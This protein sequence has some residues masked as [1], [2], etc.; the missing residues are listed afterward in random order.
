MTRNRIWTRRSFL[1][2]AS[3]ATAAIAMPAASYARIL[4][5][6]DRIRFGVVGTGGMGSAHLRNLMERRERENLSVHRVCDVYTRRLNAAVRT[7]EGNDTTGTMEY[8]DVLD[9][10]DVDTVLIAT[11]DHWHTK[12]AIEAMDAGKD[13]YVEKPLSHT[14]EQALAC[15]DAVRRTGRTL[16]VGPQGTS[17][18]RFWKAHRAIRENRIGRVTW[19]QG[20]YCRNSRGGQFNWHIDPDAG[21]QQER[22]HD[23][24]VWWDRW[25]GHE[26]D[27]APE[28]DWNAD[29]FFRFRKYFAYN[30]GLATD[31][32]YHKLAPILLAVSG[33]D[34]EYPKRVVAS[35][36]RY[37]E[38][39]ER[40]IP[41][42]FMMMVDYPTEHSVV[43]ASVMTNDVGLD[44]MIRGQYGT[45]EFNGG[46]T[47]RE[48]RAWHDEFRMINAGRFPHSEDR[49]E[50]GSVTRDPEPGSASFDV[51]TSPRRDHM[52]AFI[53]AV[54]GDGEVACNVDL[55]CSTMVAI[56]MA[57]EAYRQGKVMDWDASRER[58]VTR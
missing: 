10:R 1:Q 42:T 19:S 45:I 6:N 23:G 51:H 46:I 27:L 31:L 9:N 28:I 26:W 25:L 58:V 4:G 29:H 57:V 44:D 50:D 5:A 43:L 7:A 14:I 32:L 40:D 36:G 22:D 48:Q 55:G 11:P 52:G 12:I 47:I 3:A 39:D 17:D 24:Y 56:K 33:S 16:Q 30:G 54:R 37:L 15:R 35:G 38:K 34:G 20:S 8:R 21:P 13:V 18:D 41:D 49:A 53:D 2:T